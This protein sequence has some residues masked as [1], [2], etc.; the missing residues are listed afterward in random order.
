MSWYD[1]FS[2]FYD[3]S[4]EP[5]YRETR[6]R[7]AAALDLREGLRVLDLPTGTG[8]SL[9]EL[10][11]GVGPSGAVVGVDLSAGMLDQARRR[12][13]AAG[14]TQVALLERDVH[15]L[16]GETL[17]ALPVLDGATQVDRVHV[18]LGLSAFP[19][20]EQAFVSLWD[21]L[22]PGGRCVI[23]D[24]HADPPG[25]H[26]RMVNLVAR[27]DI[28]RQTWAPLE[29]CANDYRREELPSLPEHGGQLFLATGVK[30]AGS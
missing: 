5:L 16:D 29:R 15:A 14:W 23:V 2:R 21:R 6:A 28:R 24:V 20:W 9:P 7:A 11:A 17:A 1:L 30:P 12:V 27:A 26:G 22:S 10:V 13:E 3:R 25:F 8:A 18:F 19:E 4:L